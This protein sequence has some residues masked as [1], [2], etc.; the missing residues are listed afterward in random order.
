MLREA[1]Q[2]FL[3][4]RTAHEIRAAAIRLARKRAEHDADP[5]L[6]YGCVDWF[7]YD[8][9]SPSQEAD[10]AAPPAAAR[11]GAGRDAVSSGH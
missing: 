10:R 8:I 5:S 6:A 11:L 3:T 7:R 2:T 9:K 4:K 1:T